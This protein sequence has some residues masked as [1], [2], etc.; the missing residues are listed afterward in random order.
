MRDT[1][2]A[3]R[4]IVRFRYG[5]PNCSPPF[6]SRPE[7]RASFQPSEALAF[8]LQDTGSPLHPLGY[9][10][11]AKLPIVPAGRARASSAASLVAPSLAAITPAG[12]GFSPSAVREIAGSA[13]SRLGQVQYSSRVGLPR[14]NSRLLPGSRG[15]NLRWRRAGGRHGNLQS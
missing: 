11:G 14:R 15:A 5:P 9:D 10:N 2:S 12:N 3:F 13:Q 7:G 1:I 6:P 8:L 4:S